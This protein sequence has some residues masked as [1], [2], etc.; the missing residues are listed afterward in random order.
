MQIGGF[1]E[2]FGKGYFEDTD[3]AFQIRKNGHLAVI[4]PMS[5][6]F[7]QEGSTLGDDD[8]DSKKQLM[9]EASK[10]F[11]MKWAPQIKVRRIYS[12]D[13]HSFDHIPSNA[14]YRRYIARR[15]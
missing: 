14:H 4:Q 9:E 13:A 1:D 11:Q 15:I 6:E 8:S 3:M 10:K 2:F 12:A 5:V 7:H